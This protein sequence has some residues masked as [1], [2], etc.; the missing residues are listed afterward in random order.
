M[1]NRIVKAI[2][3]IHSTNARQVKLESQC[4]RY[5]SN[6]EWIA[7]LFEARSRLKAAETRYKRAGLTLSE[8]AQS[9]IRISDENGRCLLPEERCNRQVIFDSTEMCCYGLQYKRKVELLRVAK[10]FGTLKDWDVSHPG[11]ISIEFQEKSATIGFKQFLY[12]WINS[13]QS[14]ITPRVI[15]SLHNPC[16][17]AESSR[18]NFDLMDFAFGFYPRELNALWQ[19][20]EDPDGDRRRTSSAH[21]SSKRP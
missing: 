5:L 17:F 4:Y 8:E 20:I 10:S 3:L 19:S 21:K 15:N 11:P 9:I 7:L 13:K 1:S 14:V 16:V 2:E 6:A 12:E 18:E